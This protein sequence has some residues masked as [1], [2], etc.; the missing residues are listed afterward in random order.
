MIEDKLSKVRVSF[1]VSGKDWNSPNDFT[2]IAKVNPSE[3]LIKG[4]KRPGNRPIVPLSEWILE[5]DWTES[6]NIENVIIDLIDPLIYKK[7]EISNFISRNNLN[8]TIVCSIEIYN[9]RPGL[10]LSNSTISKIEMLSASI[11]FDI[12]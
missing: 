3:V 2:S 6:D 11:G 8:A 5:T 10:F 7:K 1:V 4:E 12:Y 9:E